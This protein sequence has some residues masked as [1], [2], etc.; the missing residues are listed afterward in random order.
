MKGIAYGVGVGPGDPELMTLKAIRLIKEND[1]I[2]VPGDVPTESVAYKIA[3]QAVPELASKHLVAIPMPMVKDRVALC[4]SHE[5]GAALIESY[6]ATGRNVVFLTLGDSSIYCT[7]T[8]LQAILEK[9][10]YKTELVNGIPSFCATAARLNVPI[11]E[12]D[13]SIHVIPAAH[14]LCEGP[15]NTERLPSGTCVLMKSGRHLKAVKE[16]LRRSGKEACMVEN[17]G[18]QDEKLY[19]SLDEIPDEAGYFTLIIAKDL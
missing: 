15:E 4:K 6:L 8:Y 17:C 18:M 11:A 12:W 1:V 10:G 19:R 9:H 5:A 13:E 16:L 2:A 3:L 7:F 14:E